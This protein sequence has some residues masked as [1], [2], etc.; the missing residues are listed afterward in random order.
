[1]AASSS[2]LEPMKQANRFKKARMHVSGCYFFCP[3]CS[4]SFPHPPRFESF[5]RI[6]YGWCWHCLRW[7]PIK[8]G[9]KKGIVRVDR[10]G[11]LYT[12]FYEE[13]D[14]E[15]AVERARWVRE[16]CSTHRPRYA[17]ES[18]TKLEADSN[19]DRQ[20]EQDKGTRKKVK[21]KS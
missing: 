3:H 8:G 7:S 17:L 13:E 15:R 9:D 16:L 1:M 4:L 5:Y 20:D 2:I 19:R 12:D 14:R 11:E 21:C 18:L 10:K 6:G